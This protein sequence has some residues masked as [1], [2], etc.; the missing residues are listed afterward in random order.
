MLRSLS[1]KQYALIDDLSI[2]FISGL[3]ILTG[4]TGAGKSII[5]G[6]LGMILGDRASSEAVRAGAAKAVVE[7]EFSERGSR[8]RAAS[9]RRG[10]LR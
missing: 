6:A 4:E 7:G 10:S 8:C 9:P 2:D 3:T 5:L 1:I